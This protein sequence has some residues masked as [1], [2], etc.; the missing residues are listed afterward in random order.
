MAKVT[1]QLLK[2]YYALGA[3]KCMLNSLK[4]LNYSYFAVE[5]IVTEKGSTFPKVTQQLT[6]APKNKYAIN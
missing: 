2:A 6:P 5:E 4:N 3:G 1:K